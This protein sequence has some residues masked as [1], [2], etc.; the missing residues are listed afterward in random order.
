M[1]ESTIEYLRRVID[2]TGQTASMIA[3]KAGV[4]P[5]TLTRALNDDHPHQ[6]ALSTVRKIEAATGVVP[7]I[8]GSALTTEEL[9][10]SAEYVAIP[11]FHVVL[12]GGPGASILDEQPADHIPFTRK[13]LQ[14]RLGRENLE[15]LA[16]VEAT[17]D[18]MEPVISTGDL[19]MID[20]QLRTIDGSIFAF[21]QGSEVFVKRLQR[22]GAGVQVISENPSVPDHVLGPAEMAD[23][24]V[25]GQVRWIGRVL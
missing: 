2:E 6:L 11:R 23:F 4:S 22:T 18:S 20:T 10:E 16:M 7:A 12:S 14:R 19:V 5:S 8:S 17:G 24:D 21:R 3:K 15:G 1:A 9:T 25:I 13:F